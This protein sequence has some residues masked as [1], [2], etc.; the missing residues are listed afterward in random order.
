MMDIMPLP[1]SAQVQAWQYDGHYAF[2][3]LSSGTGVA[4]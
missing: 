4:V 2:A 3:S 1:L